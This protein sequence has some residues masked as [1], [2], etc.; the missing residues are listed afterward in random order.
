MKPAFHTTLLCLLLMLCPVATVASNPA[1]DLKGTVKKLLKDKALG[2]RFSTPRFYEETGHSP[3]WNASALQELLQAIESSAAHGLEP[4]DYHQKALSSGDLGALELDILATDAYLSLAGHLLGGKVN[5][6]TVE[7]TW[8]ANRR[9][10]DLVAH[11]RNSLQQGSVAAS[12]AA[13][14]PQQ[15]RYRSL[16]NALAKYREIASGGG[17]GKVSGG[18]M[19]KPGATNR[20]VAEVRNRLV[21]T[22][23]L[24][25]QEGGGPEHYDE[26]LKAAVMTFQRRANLEPDGIIGPA[27]LRKL[28]YSVQDRI[29]QI[30][31]NLERWRWLPENLGKRHIR[32]NIANYELEVHEGPEI[33]RIHHVVVGRTYRQTPIF[34][35]NMS[36]LTLNPWWDV[37]AKLARN[38]LLPKF[39]A[40]ARA[41]EQLGFQALKPPG[42][43]V[44]HAGIEWNQFSSKDFPFRLRQQPGP[45]NALGKV[46]FMF[47]NEH[48]VYLHD[49][50]SRE[51]FDKTRRDFSSG[52][53]RVKDPIDLAEW[54]L[55]ANKD[56]PRSR[57]DEA[58]KTGKELTITLKQGI[59]VHL[60]YW[61]VVHDE[62]TGGIRFIE[63]I[64]SRD[65]RILQALNARP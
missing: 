50:P 42:E 53:I 1:P 62:E 54:V 15:F 48:N 59:P 35:A 26:Q 38:D 44:S 31:V 4:S 3:A 13:L 12:L 19:I 41:F 49:T 46:K 55:A 7:P 61:T 45:A 11:L 23:D 14:A 6:V 60:L 39:Q 9:E 58:L 24:V 64:Y 40:D 18:P 16:V 32:V 47:P 10:M 5:P 17:W 33:S 25:H 51:L 2:A 29:D 34:S 36:Y 30:R 56:W 65:G 27:T 63:D 21:A 57:I 20:R 37:P 22:G 43:P 8:T 28:N 52:C